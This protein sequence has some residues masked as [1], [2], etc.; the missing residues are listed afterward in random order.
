MDAMVLQVEPVTQSS[1]KEYGPWHYRDRRY[2]DIARMSF[3]ESLLQVHASA[4][5]REAPFS[6]TDQT[7]RSSSC[8]DDTPEDEGHRGRSPSTISTG[9]SSSNYA[10][11]SS[12]TQSSGS[13]SW[14]SSTS[15][16]QTPAFPFTKP[17]LKPF[18][19]SLLPLPQRPRQSIK[20]PRPLSDVDGPYTANQGCK[21]RR[22]RKD[23]V[24]SRLSRPFSFPA[25]HIIN[26]E[27]ITT[28]DKRFLKLA[29]IASAR[30]MSNAAL[31]P[32]NQTNHPSPSSLLRRAAV[33]NRFRLS[34]K[35]RAMERGDDDVANLATNAALLQQNHG[36]AFVVGARFP[37]TT[38]SVPL[39]AGSGPSNAQQGTPL[40]LSHA[41]V[42]ARPRPTSPRLKATEASRLKLPPS[43]RIR[44]I[45]SPELQSSRP[46]Y[47]ADLDDEEV[48]DDQE[49]AFPTSDLESRYDSGDDSED[50]YADFGMIFGGGAADD[51]EEEEVQDHYE[52][53]MDDM[54]GIPWT[55][56]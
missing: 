16:D 14:S 4:A 29:A 24:T 30:R 53:Y 12:T 47:M 11:S 49:V 55:V 18:D 43:P 22:L 2:S 42:E 31:T 7:E 32:I 50:V 26:R 35:N 51:E 6:K 19:F 13:I 54:D 34:V 28:G 25:T 8:I 37:V 48:F 52:D 15:T 21:K 39:L 41:A 17:I 44:P 27:F 5:V 1:F 33:I 56:R 3:G 23:M 36:V 9:S 38:S 40:H 20:R 45:R 46:T 10:L